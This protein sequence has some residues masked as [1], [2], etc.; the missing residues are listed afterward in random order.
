MSPRQMPAAATP[1]QNKAPRRGSSDAPKPRPKNAGRRRSRDRACRTRGAHRKLPTALD[2]VAD[3][4]PIRIGICQ[5]A[6]FCRIIVS[7]RSTD[8][9][10]TI[11]SSA[12]GTAM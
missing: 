4:T 2:S 12:I 5:R 1:K 10:G 11:A 8:A 6:H 7:V 9:S 3:H